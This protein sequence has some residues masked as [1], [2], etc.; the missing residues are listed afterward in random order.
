MLHDDDENVTGHSQ[1]HQH[2]SWTALCLD[3]CLHDQTLLTPAAIADLI[4]LLNTICPGCLL[5]SVYLF[6]KILH[7]GQCVDTCVYCD[8]CEVLLDKVSAEQKT[9]VCLG[10]EKD[11]VFL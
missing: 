6:N 4:V 1:R 7:F 3:R 11:V 8:A 10:C 9:A 2:Y 5:E